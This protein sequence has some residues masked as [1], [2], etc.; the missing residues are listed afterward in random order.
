MENNKTIVAFL[1]LVL[2]VLAGVGI[3][4]YVRNNA[5]EQ[6]AASLR[7]QSSA[8]DLQNTPNSGGAQNS[9]LTNSRL[10]VSNPSNPNQIRAACNVIASVTPPSIQPAGSLVVS[11]MPINKVTINNTC[12]DDVSVD[13]VALT[14]TPIG[15][16]PYRFRIDNSMF[17]DGVVSVPQNSPINNNTVPGPVSTDFIRY[18]SPSASSMAPIIIP[19]NSTKD[20]TIYGYVE[21]MPIPPDLQVTQISNL[22]ITIPSQGNAPAS[23]TLPGGYSIPA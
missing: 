2:V 20:F 23:V 17:S 12:V 21:G 16:D 1:V 18:Y 11:L 3:G 8:R 13:F 6:S 7:S 5:S 22:Q 9:N 15:P 19:A 4:R 14:L 10:S